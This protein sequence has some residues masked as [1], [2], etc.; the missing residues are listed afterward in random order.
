MY[1]GHHI[2]EGKKSVAFSLTM[3]SDDQTL[4]VE[5]ADETVKAVLKALE[6]KFGAFIR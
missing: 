1:T 2:I 4:T 5:H 3:R 6:E